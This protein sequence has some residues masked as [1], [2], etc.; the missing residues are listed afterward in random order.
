MNEKALPRQVVAQL[1]RQKALHDD[2]IQHT[3]IF[4]RRHHCP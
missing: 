2:P 1:S 4:Y 3:F